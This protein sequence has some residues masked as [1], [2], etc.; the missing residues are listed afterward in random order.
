MPKPK[1]AMALESLTSISVSVSTSV[2][3]STW[4]MRGHSCVEIVGIYLQLDLDLPVTFVHASGH[5]TWQLAIPTFWKSRSSMP[6]VFPQPV[7][8]STRQGLW[9]CRQRLLFADKLV[10][11]HLGS[12]YIAWLFHCCCCEVYYRWPESR[13]RTR[14]LHG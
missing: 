3:I 11:H 1:N 2:S 14:S 8:Q 10:L 7:C 5:K 13:A 4:R 9:I 6:E 12:L